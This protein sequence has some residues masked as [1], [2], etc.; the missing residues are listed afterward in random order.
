MDDDTFAR[1][2]G[3][4]IKPWE[5]CAICGVNSWIVGAEFARLPVDPNHATSPFAATG[6]YS[7]LPVFCSNCGYAVL[8][9]AGISGLMETGPRQAIDK[10]GEPTDTATRGATEGE[11]PS[12]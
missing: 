4:K 2:L 12:P 9:H 8:F 11:G 3:D 6:G 5:A 1:T 7:L 10:I